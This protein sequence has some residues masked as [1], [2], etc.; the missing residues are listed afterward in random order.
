MFYAYEICDILYFPSVVYFNLTIINKVESV[1]SYFF[2]LISIN[3][4]KYEF[5]SKTFYES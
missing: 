3:T 5:M 2:T 1:L 4:I